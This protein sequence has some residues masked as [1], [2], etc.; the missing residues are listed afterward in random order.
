MTW[1]VTMK[2]PLEYKLIKLEMKTEID[3]NDAQK[4]K[5][6]R[7]TNEEKYFKKGNGRIHS[8][9]YWKEKQGFQHQMRLVQR[10]KCEYV[11]EILLNSK[12]FQQNILIKLY[13][14][15]S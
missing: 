4:H 3:E 10:R 7:R 8:K 13:R 9:K 15:N 6:Y 11:K 5:K 2:I 14:K 1:L 12:H